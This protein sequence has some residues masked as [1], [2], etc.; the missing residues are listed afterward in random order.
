R[1]PRSVVRPTFAGVVF[2]LLLVIVAHARV[3]GRRD[4]LMV[5]R[6]QVQRLGVFARQLSAVCRS[7]RP[8]SDSFPDGS[9]TV[10][11]CG[12]LP[13]ADVKG[14]SRFRASMVRVMQLIPSTSRANGGG[15]KT[16]RPSSPRRVVF[17]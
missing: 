16:G 9:V 6:V 15:C 2:G 7:G 17:V 3:R 12:A 4:V 14:S 1:G 11:T 8:R 10:V 5:S 13:L